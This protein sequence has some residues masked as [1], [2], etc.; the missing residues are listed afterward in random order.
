MFGGDIDKAVENFRKATQLDPSSD[1]DF[2]WLAVAYRKSGDSASA[3]KALQQ[4]MLRNPRSAF[5][6]VTAAGTTR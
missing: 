6:K 3:E 4:A 1:E 2:V 5:A